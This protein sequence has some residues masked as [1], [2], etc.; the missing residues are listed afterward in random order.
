MIQSAWPRQVVIDPMG[1]FSDGEIVHNFTAFSAAIITHEKNKSRQ[2]RL[3][4]RF[5][6]EIEELE[7][8]L[9]AILRVCFHFQNIQVVVEEVTMFSSANYLPP[10]L[11]NC[12]FQGRHK[13]LS[14]VF[15]T[16]RPAR[17]HKDILSQC[18][19]IFAG[20]IHEKN[21]VDYM[22]GIFG[23]RAP[24]LRNISQGNF[25]YFSPG[26]QIMLVDNGY[27]K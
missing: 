25:L 9:N 6:P 27:R 20:R 24:E 17:L 16:Q 19:H 13:G 8:H 2:F 15:I 21:D 23:E 5:D 7:P 10:Y 14:L 12:L 11:R 1:E 26:K 4:C 18:T 22:S 3:I